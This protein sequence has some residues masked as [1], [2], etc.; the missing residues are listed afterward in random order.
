MIV[1]HASKPAGEPHLLNK[2]TER[3]ATAR[4]DQGTAAGYET[5]LH[6]SKL[7]QPPLGTFGLIRRPN[8]RALP[9]VRE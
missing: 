4:S 8:P 3:E 5:C 9:G 2:K 6:L 1:C 7:T